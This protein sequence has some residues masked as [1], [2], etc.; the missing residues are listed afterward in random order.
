M[1]A[2]TVRYRGSFMVHAKVP[3]YQKCTDKFLGRLIASTL[4]PDRQIR[5]GNNVVM[6]VESTVRLESSRVACQCSELIRAAPTPGAAQLLYQYSQSSLCGTRNRCSP[7][8]VPR[9]TWVLLQGTAS[10][11]RDPLCGPLPSLLRTTISGS[12]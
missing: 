6:A 3:W 12:S 10:L 7:T 8:P 1:G 2:V 4:W 9:C 11:R 5:S